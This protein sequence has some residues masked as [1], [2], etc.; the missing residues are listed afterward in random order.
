MRATKISGK[1]DNSM[2][3]RLQWDLLVQLILYMI[4]NS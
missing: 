4:I 1:I 3:K 2:E